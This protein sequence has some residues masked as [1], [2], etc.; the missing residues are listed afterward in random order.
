MFLEPT[1]YAVIILAKNPSQD[2]DV[3]MMYG[4]QVPVTQ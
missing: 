2:L 1:V 4:N 3:C